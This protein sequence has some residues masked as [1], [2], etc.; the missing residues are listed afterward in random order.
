MNALLTL[1]DTML[2]QLDALPQ[3]SHVVTSAALNREEIQRI[4]GYWKILL[5]EVSERSGMIFEQMLAARVT[6]QVNALHQHLAAYYSNP[7]TLPNVQSTFFSA[8][9]HIMIALALQEP[10]KNL[11]PT[12]QE[13]IVIRDEVEK[14]KL[15]AKIEIQNLQ[16]LTQA[17]QT[18]KSYI[19]SL[20]SELDILKKQI[21]DEN[22]SVRQI[23]SK[24]SEVQ[25]GLNAHQQTISDLLDN[26]KD[27]V[28]QVDENKRVAERK[29]KEV[30]NSQEAVVEIYDRL[31]QEDASLSKEKMSFKEQ[32]TEYDAFLLKSKNQMKQHE[33]DLSDLL[34]KA[35]STK[36]AESFKERYQSATI[37]RWVW[38]FVFL[39]DMI[40]VFFLPKIF[41]M[42]GGPVDFKTT[43]GIIPRLP[44]V[45]AIVW[46]GWVAIKSFGHQS[47]IAED[48]AFKYAIAL[49]YMSFRDHTE[50]M[51]DPALSKL[52]LESSLENFSAN[53]LRIFGANHGTPLHEIIH[54]TT[55]SKK[56]KPKKAAKKPV[57][58]PVNQDVD[59]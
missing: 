33:V 16:S 58:E 50:K 34:S 38:T 11:R 2:R 29:L 59:E 5:I 20:S 21:D 19:E 14:S 43:E 57:K 18:K 36:L 49:S 35:G 7:A 44:F 4:L 52:L 39:L 55:S 9:Q 46:I 54:S 17:Y 1:I 3:S 40:L 6:P 26:A 24:L 27:S 47:R 53:P 37:S 30:K 31:K 12:E 15:N 28:E 48:Y 32:V 56:T 23:K 8:A 10:G 45:G 13:Y 42:V 41:E 22:L 25:T 51:G